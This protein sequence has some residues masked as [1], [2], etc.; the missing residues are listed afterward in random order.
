MHRAEIFCLCELSLFMLYVSNAGCVHICVHEH[1]N[2]CLWMCQYMCKWRP[3]IIYLSCITLHFYYINSF[4]LY[5]M[6]ISMAR[7]DSNE[8]R[9]YTCL[10]IQHRNYNS[11]PLH[12]PLY[13]IA[14]YHPQVLL[15]N[16]QVFEQLCHCLSSALWWYHIREEVL[17][18]G[19]IYPRG[20]LIYLGVLLFPVVI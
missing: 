1:T 12:L 6:L 19:I 4:P 9:E 7:L 10:I 15:L 5:L 16:K 20:D 8:L 2:I 13:V 3:H 14:M 11:M 18:P 17:S